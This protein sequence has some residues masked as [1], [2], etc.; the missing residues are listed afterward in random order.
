MKGW[1]VSIA[2]VETLTQ[3]LEVNI[4]FPVRVTREKKHRRKIDSEK[5]PII[6]SADNAY[7]LEEFLPLIKKSFNTTYA[8]IENGNKSSFKIIIRLLRIN[9]GKKSIN[10][11]IK[12]SFY[13]SSFETIEQYDKVRNKVYCIVTGEKHQSWKSLELA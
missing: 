3:W 9:D 13:I 6:I 11:F 12:H 1:K 4:P 5:D 8:V 2:D 10:D 7:N